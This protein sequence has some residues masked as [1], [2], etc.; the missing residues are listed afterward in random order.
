MTYLIIYLSV[1]FSLTRFYYVCSMT[2]PRKCLF[3]F[4]YFIRLL[5]RRYF[6]NTRISVQDYNMNRWKR[7]LFTNIR[8]YKA[9]FRY[10]R[11]HAFLLLWNP[12]VNYDHPI[13]GTPANGILDL[14][15]AF[16]VP[17]DTQISAGKS[18]HA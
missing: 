7:I 16:R 17:C 10:A 18:R 2:F 5:S 9:V 4:F 11:V 12:R 8:R 6:L 15:Y 1:C 14:R 3:F 13:E